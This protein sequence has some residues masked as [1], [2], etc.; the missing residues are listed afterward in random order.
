[1]RD[2]WRAFLLSKNQWGR[3][4]VAAIGIIVDSLGLIIL[5]LL[6]KQVFDSL[7]ALATGG[8]AMTAL[9]T[10]VK[11]I[12]LLAIV[13]SVGV[14]VEIYFQEA[15]GSYISHDVRQLLIKR[16]LQLPFS[17]FDRTKTGDLMSVLTRDVDAVRDGTGFVV[18]LIVVNGLTAIGIIVA[19][20]RLHAL[21]ALI[22]LATFPFLLVLAVTYS[23]IVGPMYRRVQHESGEL[24]TVSQENISGIRVVK[25]FVRNQ[26]EEAKF[27]NTSGNLYRSN[28]RIA[29]LNSKVHPGLDFLGGA[30]SWIALG[31][32]GLMV[33]R[34]DITLG[35]MIA[36]QNFAESLIWPIRS[37]G[38][39]SEM[40]QRATAGARRVFRVL[41]EPDVLRNNHGKKIDK[42]VEGRITFENVGFSYTEDEEAIKN[43]SLEIKPGQTVCILGT[44][45]S[46][47]TTVANLIPRFYDA[48]SGSVKID[49]IDVRD[50]DLDALRRQIG[51]VF[52]DNFLFSSTLRDNLTMGY[53]VEQQQLDFATEV[54]QAK[55]FITK[56]PRAYETE[57]GER[58]IGLSGGERQ[59]VAIARALLRDPKILVFDDSS[60][61]LDV[62]TEAELNRALKQLFAGRT[63]VII[64]QRVSTAME[65]DQIVVLEDG[66][67][68]QQGTHQELLA[69]EGLYRHL[70]HVQRMQTSGA[71]AVGEVAGSER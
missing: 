32:G 50:W 38:W 34:G 65:A 10:G 45:G 67:M 35:T 41:D 9:I 19:M 40:L 24:H 21:F 57:V 66:E 63:V 42:P 23:K 54:A 17:F 20:F 58:G 68:V 28:L 29:F 43:F 6:L 2:Y 5:P 70:Y 37:I 13:R 39:L 64:A 3:R 48:T 27:A 16:L 33:I 52:Q 56:L 36:F 47:K 15:T 4:I 44:T 55:G 22:V 1:M 71:R 12:V 59:R 31:A 7:S 51:F 69:Q 61:S 46:G 26:E 14:Y 18:M 11:W 62:K 30:A 60:S 53:G 25:A 49:G 8:E